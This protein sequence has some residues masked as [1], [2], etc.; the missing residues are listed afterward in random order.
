MITTSLLGPQARRIVSTL[1]SA[2]LLGVRAQAASLTVTPGSVSNTYAGQIT[3][4]VTGLT[5]GE[6]V[7]LE[8]F[9]DVNAN[10]AIDTNDWLVSSSVLTDGQSTSFGGV[11]NANIPGDDDAVAGQIT[12]SF[13]LPNSPELGRVA[14]THLV[15]I[16][17]PAGRFTPIVQPLTIS[18]FAYSQAI[19]GTILNGASPVPFAG[20]GLLA[21]VGSD[22]V[23][24]NGAIAD[25][26]GNFL[27][28]A[29]A[30]SYVVFAVQPGFVS[31]FGSLQVILSPNQNVNQNVNV[32]PGPLLI[33]GKVSDATTG[34][35]LPAVQIVLQS[36]NNL[37]A[38][39]LTDSGGNF[40]F[41]VTPN[42][43]KF[44][45]S[46]SGLTAMGYLRP[47]NKP[48]ISVGAS[49]V[50]GVQ[51]ALAKMSAM[52]YG[53]VKND[54]NGLMPQIR[55]SGSD[56]GGLYESSALT[57]ANGK[58]YVGILG[59]GTWNVGP[60]N[61]QAALV[62]YTVSSTNVF[63]SN[64][65]AQQVNFIAQA[66]SA[67]LVGHVVNSSGLPIPGVTLLA[68]P[69]NGG[70]SSASSATAADGSFD[71]AVPGG[72]WT[73]TLETGSAAA[74]SLIGP[75]LNFSI[76]NST[77]ISGIVYVA[78][79]VTAMISGTV[80][81]SSN[82]PIANIF[83]FANTS[84]N[85]TNYNAAAQTD[86][87]GN[88]S[89]GVFNGVWQLS[90]E[91]SGLSSLGYGC[92]NNQTVT[93]NGAN[94]VAN[95]I[96]PPPA[97]YS[98]FFR[99]FVFGGDFGNGLT[100]AATY[101]ITVGGY[102]AVL[103]AQNDINYPPLG[104]VFFTGPPGSGMNNAPTSAENLGTNSA[105][106]IS[107]RV[108]N[109]PNAP[110]GTWNVNYNG[111]LMTFVAP[112]P[113]ISTHLVI[114]RPTITLSNNILTRVTWLYTDVNGNAL[115]GT[116]AVVTN[117]QVQ[118]FDQELNPVDVSALLPP[119]T[120]SY[121]SVAGLPWTTIGR[122]R[123][124][125]TDNLDNRYLVNFFRTAPGLATA[126]F[127]S[128]HRFQLLL[129]GLLGQNYTVQFST[130]L[131]NWSTLLVTNAPASSFTVIDPTLPGRLGFYRILVGP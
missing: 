26:S 82:N 27:I 128:N 113:Q 77:T 103:F 117:I 8:R 57:D 112:D 10:G 45:L 100:P 101:P 96:V 110:G 106:Y 62:G 121:S 75:S 2:I 67:H 102:N 55:V 53:T 72:N 35:G 40:S 104:N 76:A 88:Y 68:I 58:Y 48:K 90:L 25:A 115:A 43:W 21:L 39:G 36:T 66:A 91:C 41:A 118:I 85:G 46:D 42:Q 17:S 20:I 13:S 131:T 37:S 71:L 92:P 38:L 127:D 9:L 83:V 28:R 111:N 59:G 84:I 56:N 123:M 64:G 99:H 70:P 86:A 16:S 89:L 129:N 93:I 98:F 94:G 69:Q 11:R 81:N 7:L 116:P 24:I 12:T 4:Q 50:S 108:N 122:I 30:G 65:Q 14:G 63:L 44:D 60:D 125:Y 19:T 126:G 54:T 49:N 15:R 114:P 109:P 95:F 130:T 52:V 97:Q 51:L 78:Q 74:N 32:T 5:N 61:S 3:L 80:K 22:V 124:V 120:T 34:A 79:T 105:S 18:Q 29:A 31:P 87:N 107:L 47:Q 119:A 23:F 1:I 33:S 73:V 6:T